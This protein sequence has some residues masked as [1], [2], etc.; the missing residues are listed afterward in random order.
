MIK[1][2]FFKAQRAEHKYKGCT[3]SAPCAQCDGCAYLP[4]AGGVPAA[5]KEKKKKGK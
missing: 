3:Q 1:C 2:S 5:S 4:P